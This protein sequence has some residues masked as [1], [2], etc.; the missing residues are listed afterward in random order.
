M[1]PATITDHL[2]SELLSSESCAVLFNGPNSSVTKSETPIRGVSRSMRYLHR[3]ANSQA[4]RVPAVLCVGS[5]YTSRTAETCGVNLMVGRHSKNPPAGWQDV[6]CRLHPQA[7]SALAS[8]WF[9][10]LR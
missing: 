6:I 8:R 7:R 3:I 1:W 9:R 4:F 2:P 10:R 5:A